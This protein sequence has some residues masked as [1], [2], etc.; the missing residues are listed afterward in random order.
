MINKWDLRF[1][2]KAKL[3]ASWS[4]DRSRG[5]GCVIVDDNHRTISEGYNGF[6]NKFN[7]DIDS[8][9]DRPNKYMYTI[10]AEQNAIF[11]AAKNGIKLD[12]CTIYCTTLHICHECARAIIQTGIKRV[13]CPSPNFIDPNFGNSFKVAIE[14]FNE[15]GVILEY[16][17]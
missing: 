11:S 12:R 16:F 5:V 1:I 9:H 7:D 8:R 4:K 17:D 15:C 3:I 6:P 13:V 10:H 2:E 14:M